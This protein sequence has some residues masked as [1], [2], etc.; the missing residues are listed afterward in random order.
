[1]QALTTAT[2][3]LTV[4]CF[5]APAFDL[6]WEA[7]WIEFSGSTIQNPQ[8]NILSASGFFNDLATAVLVPSPTPGN[9]NQVKFISIYNNDAAVQTIQI[10]YNNPATNTQLQIDLN[11]GEQLHYI[12]SHGWYVLTVD[13]AL[14]IFDSG[15][16]VQQTNTR[17]PLS[18][19]TANGRPIAV[20]ATATPGTLIHTASLTALDEITLF[21]NNRS[22]AA[23][24]LTIEFG[25]T[26]NSDHIVETLSLPANSGPVLISDGLV[27]T[28]GIVVRA[29]SGTAN[30]INIAGK[31]NRIS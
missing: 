2:Q 19:G 23:A 11:P 28:G 20:A 18:G 13:G 10:C 27:L 14:K 16:P 3:E 8:A 31:V 12:D 21:A 5:L 1:M 30:A 9:Q 7:S 17:I 25:G 24:T 6:S 22:A 26:A 29:F 15:A 4:R